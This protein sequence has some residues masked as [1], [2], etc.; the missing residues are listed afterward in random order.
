MHKFVLDTNLF[1]NLQRPLNLGESKEAVVDSLLKLASP[2]INK[3]SLVLLT[4]PESF[5]E[6]SSFFEGQKE[7]L[8]QLSLMLTISSPNTNELKVGAH[9]FNELIAETGR[10]LY[11]G[12]RVAEEPLKELSKGGSVP[13]QETISKHINNLRDK[14][15]RATREGFID[16]TVDLSLIFL[17][18]DQDAVLVSSDAGLLHWARNFGCQELL[19][20]DFVQKIKSLGQAS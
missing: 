5:K 14:Y 19:P 3:R 10:R 18:R 13:T 20:E 1:I 4:T 2:L 16:S 9:L 6:L 11:R 17:S 12:L 7:T 8:K 15:R